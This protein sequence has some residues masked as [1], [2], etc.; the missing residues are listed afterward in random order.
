M[1]NYEEMILGQNCGS[2]SFWQLMGRLAGKQSKTSNIPLLQTPNDSYVFTDSEMANTL[3]DYFCSISSIDDTYSNLPEFTKRTNS[4]LSNIL[5]SP[6]EVS[7]ILSNLKLNKASGPDGISH[8][9]LKN[10]SGSIATP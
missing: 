1:N 6:S 4:S 3:N 8:R 9:M 5:I 7:D 2:K 10:T